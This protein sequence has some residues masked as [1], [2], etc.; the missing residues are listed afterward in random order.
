MLNQPGTRVFVLLFMLL[1][2]LGARGAIEVVEKTVPAAAPGAA[3]AAPS[4]LTLVAASVGQQIT[5]VAVSAAGRVFVNFPR[6]REGVT[7]SVG[8][9]QA[10][11]TIRPYPDAEWN[12]WAAGAATDGH[13]VC[14]QSVVIDDTDRMWVLDPSSPNMAGV[15]GSPKLMQV[16][17]ATNQ[18]VHTYWFEASVAP[19]ESYLN[20]LRV[21]TQAGK[22][23]ITDSGLGA[24]VVLDIA[25]GQARRLLAGHPSVQAEALVLKVE[26]QE[27]RR[28]DGSAPQIHSDGIALDRANGYLYYHALTGYH[29]YRIR[30]AHLLDEALDAAGLAA[31]VEDLGTTPAPDGMIIDAAGNLYMG[32]LE[33]N[34]IVYRTP[35][36]QRQTLVSDPKLKW[37]DTFA[38]GPDNMLYVACSR[39]H[40]T[41]MFKP[42][43]DVATMRFEVFK[44]A[45]AAG[46]K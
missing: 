26:G 8:E 22:I 19:A 17:L 45:L 35:E 1:L 18:V 46:G 12:T 6:W 15:V 43:A 24:I 4:A 5:G 32:D 9:V 21:D 41:P 39:I 33:T 28:G 16:D 36:G 42:G 10:D 23:Y 44:T 30:T 14:V 13:F 3:S 29:L 25:T 2:P 27:L 37:P 38:I 7:M 34:S 40:E 11:G 31:L 20:D